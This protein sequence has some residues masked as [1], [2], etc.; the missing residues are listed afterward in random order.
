MTDQTPDLKPHLSPS[1]CNTW[2]MCPE[3]WRRRYIEGEV[4]PPGVAAHRG[5]GVH[6]G[7][8]IN[9]DQKIESHVDLPA[10]DIVDASVAAFEHAV[11]SKG[12]AMTP[13]E[14][15]RGATLVGS[16]AKDLTAAMA[17]VHADEVA[18]DYQPII[19]EEAVRIVMPSSTHDLF[20]YVDL[21]AGG[22]GCPEQ[23][24][25]F[26][27]AG[28][29]K[30]Q[31][32]VDLSNQ[33][34]FYSAASRVLTGVPVDQVRLEVLVGGKRGVKRQLLQSTRGADDYA[35]LAHRVNAVLAG[36]KAGIFG[37][38]PEGAWWCG[39]KWCG[40]WST[41]PFVNNKRGAK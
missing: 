38:A 11:E 6:G 26:K 25:D 28:K 2:Q 9:F 21:I 18:P 5:T 36:I 32:D 33:L 7:A 12:Y 16:D 15:A 30:S 14:S 41:C 27:T 1:Q 34:T 8:Q 3:R 24:V 23:V 22:D 19:V 29:S 39:P 20:G 40:Y 4:I 10:E 17:K 13:E 31:G 35:V 37:P